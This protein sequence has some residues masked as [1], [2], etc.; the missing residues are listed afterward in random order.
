VWRKTPYYYWKNSV[1]MLS[2]LK[3]KAVVGN[4]H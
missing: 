2:S 4:Q 3:N 1:V